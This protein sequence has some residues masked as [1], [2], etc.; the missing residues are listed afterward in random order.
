MTDVGQLALVA[1]FIIAL[2]TM[3][4]SA[5]GVRRGLVEMLESSYNGVLAVWGLTTVAAV[6]LI[7][8]LISHDFG[9]RYVAE[10]TSR[11]M[12][13]WYTISAFWA[14]QEGSLLLWAWVLSIFAA[15]V[16]V[17]N[18]KRNRKIIPYVAAVMMG[19]QAFFLGLLVFASNPFVRL[20]SPPADGQG[21]NPLLEN[22]GM[23]FHPPTLYLGYVGFTVPFAFCLAALVSGQ[24]SDEWIRSTRRWTLIA[25]FFLGLGN[26]LGA[27]WAY[28]ELGWGGY[29]GWD[30]VENASLMPWL[31]GTAYLHSVMIQQRR[32][33]LK[34][35]NVVLIIITFTL[36]LFGTFLTRSGILSSVHAFGETSLG[37]PFL[38]LIAAI[39]LGS[40]G[41][42]LKRLPLLK[43]ENELDSMLS[44]ESG[45]LLN[46]LILLGAAFAT[47]WGTIFPLISEA[48]RGVKITVSAPY[49]NQVNGP[50]FGLLI[51]LMGICTL[52]GWRKASVENLLRNFLVPIIM[53]V[54]LGIILW[55]MGV[56][57]P[58]ALGGFTAC[59]FVVS[60]ILFDFCRAVSVRYRNTR[61]N[62]FKVI[63]NLIW[64][65]KPRYGGYIVH[66]GIVL[67]A[68]G[69]TASSFYPVEKEATLA[70]GDT[71]AI[72]DYTLKYM[73][74]SEYS[75]PSKQVIA[76]TVEVYSGDKKIDTLTSEKYYHKGHENPVT[77]VAIR[78]T[79]LED[80]YIILAGWD[81]KSGTATF[82]VLV[83]P[84]VVWIWIG[85]GVLLLGTVVAVWPDARERRRLAIEYGKDK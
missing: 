63:V 29:W 28:V 37:P 22:P 34:V 67:I 18:R 43:G 60:T 41:L 15:I 58:Y 26:L 16:L 36:V 82:K 23:F 49:F 9:V 13:I 57:E 85:G 54:I 5:L 20:V 74:L 6:S 77:E 84:L 44:R 50:I 69:I 75:T 55:A 1:A 39:L 33:M 61:E 25:W 32:G 7:Y 83:N 4:A 51:A 53:A 2:Y 81:A 79:P 35:W 11:D 14:G 68:I 72:K 59:G 56:R 3:V 19:I 21:L 12:S 64:S 17:Q 46:N 45:F 47:F 42:L 62:P 30:P 52:I 40:L 66:L 10:Y 78:T 70:V 27:Q 24:L 8:L 31:T 73:G 65:N 48:V 76:G 38:T 80:L 71:L